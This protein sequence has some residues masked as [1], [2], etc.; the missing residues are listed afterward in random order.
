V[1]TGISLQYIKDKEL[2]WGDAQWIKP[3]IS[4]MMD[5]SVGVADYQCRQ[6]PNQ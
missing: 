1:G 5:G 2:D 6:L 4:I 3:L